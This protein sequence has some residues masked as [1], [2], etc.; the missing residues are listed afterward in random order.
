M[1]TG[2]LMRGRLRKQPVRSEAKY[3]T[4]KQQEQKLMDSI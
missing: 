2:C 1:P 4:P 3:G